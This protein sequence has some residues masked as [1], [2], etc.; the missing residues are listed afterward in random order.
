MWFNW[1][2]E[3]VPMRDPGRIERR[4]QG[5]GLE[6]SLTEFGDPS[7]ST[8]VL[9]HGFPDTSAVW[10]P[11]VELL[12]PDF[13]VV[14]Y[15][16]RGAGNSDVPGRRADYRLPLLVE[17]MGAVAQSVSP[18]R[19]VHLVAHDWGSI[20]AW[21]AVT[22]EQLTGR[23]ASFTSISGPPLDHAALWARSHRSWRP[24]DLRVAIRQALHSWYIAF[25]HLPYLPKL[26]T[27]GETNRRLWARALHRM[28]QAPSDD[29]W[30]ASTF[31]DD[32][33]HGLELYRANVRQRFRHP[34]VGHTATPVQIIVPTKDRYVTPAL[35]NGLEAWSSTV[36][37]R[38]VDAGHW[39]IR[40][41]PS[42]V[43]QWVREAIAF[44]DDGTEA[45]DLARCRVAAPLPAAGVDTEKVA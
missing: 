11:L 41:H 8:I 3:T 17:D 32:F 25:F 23:F 10:G 37:R 9:V 42:D 28:E 15:D 7:R 30:P 12:A 33:A 40:S 13:H 38:E 5:A 44:A 34:M 18:N 24:S 36:W 31:S 22:S 45:P 20:Q 1:V 21:P 6:L 16:V 14:T 43:A 39:V 27:R 26:I 29:N 2:M 35:L 4:I 19:P